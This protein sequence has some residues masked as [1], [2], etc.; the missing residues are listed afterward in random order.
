[1]LR[2]FQAWGALACVLAVLLPCASAL[3]SN[4]D[5]AQSVHRIW[6]NQPGLR[7]STINVVTQTSDGYIWLG[8]PSGV[9]RFDGLRFTSVPALERASLGDFW[10]R[11]IVEDSAHAVW[12]ISNN[13]FKLVRVDG[14]DVKV[15]AGADDSPLKEASCVAP[16]RNGEIWVCTPAGLAR[17]QSG[18]WQNFQA[19]EQFKKPATAACQM[20]GNTVWMAG[21]STITSWDGSAFATHRITSVPPD[22]AMRTLLCASDSS[23]WVGTGNG[24]VQVKDGEEHLYTNLSGLPDNV[25]TSLAE[26]RGGNLWIGTSNG[27]SRFHDGVFDSYGYREGLSQS[28]VFSLFEDREGSLWVATKHGLNQFLDGAATRFTK[29]EGLPSENVGPLL[30]DHRGRLWAGTLDGGLARFDGVHFIPVAHFSQNRVT[31]L[32]ETSDGA[33]WAGTDH[34]LIRL[35]DGQPRGTFATQQGLPSEKIHA[36]FQDH[37]GTLWAG[38]QKGPARFERGRFT[39]LSGS[40]HLPIVAIGETGD[41]QMLFA[42]D[43]GSVYILTNGSLREVMDGGE[44]VRNVDAFYTDPEGLV[45]MGATANGLRMWRDGKVSR[46][47]VRDGLFDGEIYGILPDSQGRLWMSCSKG[48][49]SVSRSELL[50][51][52]A[53]KVHKIASAP[54]SPLDG[55]RTIEG[56][57]GVQPVGATTPDGRLWFS[58]TYGVLAFESRAGIRDLPPPPVVIEDISVNGESQGVSRIRNLAPGQR[59]LEFDYTATTL[60]AS[61]RTTFRYMLEGYDRNWIDAGTRRE[62]F[63]TNLPPGTF[64]FRV[65]ACGL[66]VPCNEVGATVAFQLAPSIYQRVWFLPACAALLGLVGW[67]GYQFRIRQLREQ[68]VLVLGER[69]RIA[70]ELHDTLIQGFSGITMQMQALAARVHSPEEKQ[71]LHE[72]I[73]DAGACLQE[74]RR[75]VAGLRASAGA[76]PGLALAIKDAARQIT[77]ERN[78]RLKLNLD[79]TQPDL[80][81]EVKYNLLCI[82]QEA[83]SNAVKHSGARTVEVGLSCSEK[84]LKLWVRDDGRGMSRNAS[85]GGNGHYGL[86]GMR[87]RAGHIRAGFELTS[88]PGRGTQISVQVPVN[89]EN[90]VA[91]SPERQEEADEPIRTHH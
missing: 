45:W 46:F 1:M 41:G 76:S 3:D 83:V 88:A 57:Q 8:T 26:G 60:L 66:F 82:A 11:I 72:I 54:F 23:L 27:F 59:N 81:A 58:S 61:D 12:I 80:P 7:Q 85:Y 64:R 70:R 79:D 36:L 5:I 16:G 86:I 6:Q 63:Y 50:S 44:P 15:L 68:F 91:S 51:F 38:T 31:S 62:A 24:L 21:G 67:L 13:D 19:P 34:G 71:S 73:R 17:F 42:A 37:S 4:H 52:A 29:H 9:V 40:G 18:Q 43:R 87:E 25:I 32:A 69:S 75:S 28:S 77:Q 53:G 49:F 2:T 22:S 33:L 39:E 47:L 20:A 78:I 56:K 48:F 14:E 30:R 89:Q 55:L 10:A 90:Y 35:E 74:T 84:E 65:T